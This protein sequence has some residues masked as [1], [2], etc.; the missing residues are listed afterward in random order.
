MV[1]SYR[2]NGYGTWVV[3]PPLRDLCRGRIDLEIGIEKKATETQS[4]QRK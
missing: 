2:E 4:S 3:T 1:S